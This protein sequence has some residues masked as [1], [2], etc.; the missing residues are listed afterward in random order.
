MNDVLDKLQGIRAKYLASL[1]NVQGEIGI[2]QE[3]VQSFAT[4]IANL[5]EVIKEVRSSNG[6]DTP[7]LPG[8]GKYSRSRLTDA[9]ADVVKI[10]GSP[11]GLSAPDI[12]AKLQADGFK[13]KAKKFY[14]SVYSVAQTLVEKGTIAEGTKDGKRSFLRKVKQS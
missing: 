12:M 5:D 11:P 1:E 4:K 13:S 14:A 10:W 7:T 2:L 9:I 6:D 3:Q 8:V